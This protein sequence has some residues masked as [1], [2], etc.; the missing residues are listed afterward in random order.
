MISENDEEKLY[1][2]LA[3][4][5]T[6]ESLGESLRKKAQWMGVQTQ[7]SWRAP[8]ERGAAVFGRLMAGPE[9][10]GRATLLSGRRGRGG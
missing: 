7:R 10:A 4:R 8:L 2:L 9:A 3:K 5:E 1:D 6:Y